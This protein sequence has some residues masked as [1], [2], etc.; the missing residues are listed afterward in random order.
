M[1]VISSVGGS[2][3]VLRNAHLTCAIVSLRAAFNGSYMLERDDES[4]QQENEHSR[5]PITEEQSAKP[6][7]QTRPSPR[8]ALNLTNRRRRSISRANA[9]S[10]Y[11]FFHDSRLT[12][13]P[14]RQV[15]VLWEDLCRFFTH[16]SS[17]LT[18]KAER[19]SRQRE[20]GFGDQN[21]TE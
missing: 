17:H 2:I 16:A 19:R 18:A 10:V 20:G 15:A 11:L 13:L 5:P 9:S 12:L 6:D 8:L 1:H 4:A 7:P 21:K 14:P 3:L